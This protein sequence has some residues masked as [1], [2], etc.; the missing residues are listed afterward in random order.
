VCQTSAIVTQLQ[1]QHV[2]CASCC[3]RAVSTGP[4]MR[5]IVES[6][7]GFFVKYWTTG[8]QGQYGRTAMECHA[9]RYFRVD[10]LTPI[11]CSRGAWEA[12]IISP[13]YTVV[14]NHDICFA[15][16]AQHSRHLPH[17]LVRHRL[18]HSNRCSVA[19]S[20]AVYSSD[21]AKRA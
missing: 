12:N 9:H 6:A 21:L 7:L 20:A 14:P 4:H 19:T 10:N 16:C 18:W 17:V 2:S 11:A 5:L 13:G 1:V 3:W 8:L 15:N